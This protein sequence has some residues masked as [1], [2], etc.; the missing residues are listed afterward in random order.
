MSVCLLVVCR[1][2]V[3][4]K[5]VVE[6]VNLHGFM[7]KKKKKKKREREREKERE[8]ERNVVMQI[9]RIGRTF[10]VCGNVVHLKGV[11]FVSL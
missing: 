10:F 9:G 4:A 3:L 11:E 2:I 8:R 1:C 7:K 6:I 5:F